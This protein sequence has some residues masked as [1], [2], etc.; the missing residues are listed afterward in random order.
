MRDNNMLQILKDSSYSVVLSGAGL[1]AESGYP[2]LRDGKESYEIEE[3]YGYS[4]EEIFS[5]AFYSARKEL[6]FRFYKDVIL[7][8]SE[9]PPGK[10]FQALKTLQ[11]Y[12][13]VDSIITRRIAGLEDRAGCRNVL[14]M[15]G[16]VFDNVC[17]GCGKKYP[18][19]Y[20]KSAKG[21]PLCEKCMTAIRPQ[22]CLFGEM[23]NNAV[24]TQA[25]EEVEKA[26]TLLVL[27]AN[28]ATPL[29][30][31]LIQYFAGTN[32]ILVTETEH[33]SDQK[34]D[35]VIRG[36]SDEF[37]A[38]MVS[39]YEKENNEKLKLERKE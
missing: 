10:G 9:V 24:M 34:A 1:M 33:F 28:L 31:Q 19:E 29:C 11:D 13:L 37:L 38:G 4:F 17:P 27:G 20:M 22:V 25:A 18:V 36:R 32:L 21:V 16:T 7:K 30:S 39:E 35:I 12:G 26:D 15:K 8:A 2:L 3:K 5:S 6:F 23:I 14:N